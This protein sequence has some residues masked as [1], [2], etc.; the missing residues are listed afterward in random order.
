MVINKIV[1]IEAE[2]PLGFKNVIWFCLRMADFI[3]FLAD[4]G[5][6]TDIMGC[7]IMVYKPT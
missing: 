6:P 3:Y 2:A 5:R 4:M 7:R 1:M